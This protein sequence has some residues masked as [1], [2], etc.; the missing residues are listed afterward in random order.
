MYIFQRLHCYKSDMCKT[1]QHNGLGQQLAC[2]FPAWNPSAMQMSNWCSSLRGEGHLFRPRP[3]GQKAQRIRTFSRSGV[4][5]SYFIRTKVASA[6]PQWLDHQAR[7]RPPHSTERGVLCNDVDGCRMYTIPL[8]ITLKISPKGSFLIP[9]CLSLHL[10]GQRF[11]PRGRN[12]L[13]EKSR[14]KFWSTTKLF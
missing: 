12:S 1:F 8:P 5:K 6:K 14:G 9:Q 3:I 2:T 10:F 13:I 11:A 4:P 7:V